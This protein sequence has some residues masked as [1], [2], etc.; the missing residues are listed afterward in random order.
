MKIVVYLKQVPDTGARI[1]LSQDKNSISE[2][3]I[4]WIINPYDEFALEEALR[5]KDKRGAVGKTNTQIVVCSVGPRRAEKA[6]RTA[7][8]MGA[9]EACLIETKSPSAPLLAATALASYIKEE[10]SM[11]LMGKTSIDEDQAATGPM[12]AELLKLPHVGFVTNLHQKEGDIWQAT[13]QIEAGIKQ[14]ITFKLP[15]LITAE[16]GLNKP[17]YPS[18]PGIMR[19]KKKPLKVLE[20]NSLN[21][22]SVPIQ[23]HS[24]R[25]PAP[26]PPPEL[27][28]GSVDEQA[29]KLAK[30]LK[31]R[32]FGL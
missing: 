32:G 21:L 11:V 3:G 5:I 6:L 20:L 25:L 30:L 7:L 2:E 31:D 19:A 26:S 23:F 12:L 27:I 1:E 18:L 8:A 24:Y 28:T 14:E 9:D 13:R 29:T 16:K 22:Q 10:V 17:R 15:A 4:E